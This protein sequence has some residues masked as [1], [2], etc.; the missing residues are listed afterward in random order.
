MRGLA[1]FLL[2]GG[3]ALLII[4]ILG[5]GVGCLGGIGGALEGDSGAAETGGSIAGY[6]IILFF[7]S[8]MMLAAGAI[9]KATNKET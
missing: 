5:I 4:S 1:R 2:W 7:L 3:L 8:L 9:I 6:S